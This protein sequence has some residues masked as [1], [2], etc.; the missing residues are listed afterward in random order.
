MRPIS[1]L[2]CKLPGGR[3]LYILALHYIERV[4]GRREGREGGMEGG[5]GRK[6]KDRDDF[7][8]MKLYV[9]YYF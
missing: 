1:H 4:Q 2:Q 6:G 8:N 9:H 3:D 5:R 7:V